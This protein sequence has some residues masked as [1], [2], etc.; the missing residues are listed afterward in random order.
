MIFEK[1]THSTLR[2][3]LAKVEVS[4]KDYQTITG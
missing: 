3:D 1:A 2:V 4:G